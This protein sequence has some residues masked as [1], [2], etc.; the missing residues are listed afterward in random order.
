MTCM[1]TVV[2]F[3]MARILA[4]WRNPTRTSIASIAVPTREEPATATAR[5]KRDRLSGRAAKGI[6]ADRSYMSAAFRY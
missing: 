5:G 4:A 3:S 1:G 2:S 6:A